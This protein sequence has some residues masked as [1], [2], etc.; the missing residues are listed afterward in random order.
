MWKYL[1]VTN[2]DNKLLNRL[3]LFLN[4]LQDYILIQA[5]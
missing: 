2:H 3:L 1:K 5:S 4:H